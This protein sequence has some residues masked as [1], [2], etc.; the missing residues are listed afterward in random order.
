MKILIES[1]TALLV[2]FITMVIATS[3][4]FSEFMVGYLSGAVLIMAFFILTFK[5]LW[6]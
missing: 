4:G 1:I 5:E 3:L 2:S 6:K